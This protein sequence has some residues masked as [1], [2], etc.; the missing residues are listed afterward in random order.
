MLICI[1]YLKIL[2]SEKSNP[3]PP[4]EKARLEKERIKEQYEKFL[5]M[6]RKNDDDHQRD[7]KV[8]IES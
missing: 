2:E 8:C 3:I 5:L 6:K 1:N 7:K 4:S